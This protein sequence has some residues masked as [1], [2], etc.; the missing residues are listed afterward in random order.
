MYKSWNQIEAVMMQHWQSLS[1]VLVKYTFKDFF[2]KCMDSFRN[3]DSECSS[4]E[5]PSSQHCDQLQSFLKT[6]K[7]QK[8]TLVFLSLIRVT[9]ERQG[10]ESGRNTLSIVLSQQ[11]CVLVTLS[12]EQN[13]WIKNNHIRNECNHICGYSQSKV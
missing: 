8:K 6:K 10:I 12:V 1:V 5:E 4:T 7:K 11:M 3:Y 9:I 2:I 13:V